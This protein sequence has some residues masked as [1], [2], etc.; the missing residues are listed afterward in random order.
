MSR[1]AL[2]AGA[3]GLVGGLLLRRLLGHVEY[4]EV[5]VLGRRP[6]SVEGGKVRFVASDFTNFAEIA[7][8][9]AVD[10]VFCCLG[11][12][13]RQA[14]SE[15]A[16]ERVDYHMVVDLARAAK[17]AGARRFLVVSAAGSSLKSPAFYSRLKARMEKAVV[18]VGF[19]ATHIVR[20]SL[21]LGSR[22]GQQRRP[23]ELL[24]QA[25]APLYGPFM[26][27]PLKKYRPVPAEAVAAALLTLALR[28][29]R[30]P[31]VHHLPLD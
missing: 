1:T 27:G 26:L 28:D 24:A 19:E 16:F 23:G 31:H 5:R 14:G 11:T 18:E 17:K 3:T 13:I 22:R 30:G 15:A 6:P 7:G 4:G 20:P 29:A 21:L 12:T 10:D 8:E 25:L 2:V 9:I